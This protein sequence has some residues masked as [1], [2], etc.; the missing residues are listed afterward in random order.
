MRVQTGGEVA[1]VRVALDGDESHTVVAG[2]PRVCAPV[3][4]GGPK[5]LF[6]A[7]G[8]TEPGDLYLVDLD[9]GDE[10][11]LTSVHEDVLA[12]LAL[13]TVVPLHFAGIDGAPVEGWFLQPAGA[14][15]A[16][17]T[18]LSIHGGP[19]GAW[20]A[21]FNFDHLMFAGAGYGVLLVNHRAS[22]GYGERVRH[23]D[24]GRL[25]QPRL[26]RPDVRRRLTRSRRGW[27]TRTGSATSTFPAAATSRAG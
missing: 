5:V 27:P 10:R 14:E 6:G 22:T 3:S 15:T 18:V 2:G 23:R 7:F 16:L 13:P 19:H 12:E 4:A 9:T 24:P 17:P 8:F 20:G 25:G 11:R 21:H 26:R 1:I